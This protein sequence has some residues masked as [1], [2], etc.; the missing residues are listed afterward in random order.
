MTAPGVVQECPACGYDLQPHDRLRDG[1]HECRKCR[2]VW[3]ISE[4]AL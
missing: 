4:V 2:R 1:Q 3:S